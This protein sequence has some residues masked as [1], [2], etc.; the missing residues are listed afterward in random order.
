MHQIFLDLPGKK[1]SLPN[2][3]PNFPGK[4]LS[5]P[6]L[7]CQKVNFFSFLFSS[8]WKQSV[9]YLTCAQS[10][11]IGKKFQG[12]DMGE[13]ENRAL[14][15]PLTSYSASQEQASGT[16]LPIFICKGS[17]HMSIAREVDGRERN[18][19]QKACFGT[20]YIWKGRKTTWN[21]YPIEKIKLFWNLPQNKIFL[22]KTK[23]VLTNWKGNRKKITQIL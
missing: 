15:G 6:N 2:L 20:L 18:V 10:R 22:E 3:S 8:H 17:L 19:P 21:T 11:T 12:S 5:L 23:F 1:L 16:N 14:W 13:G 9:A 7:F 4:K